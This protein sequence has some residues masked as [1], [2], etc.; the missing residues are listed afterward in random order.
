MD[1]KG[2]VYSCDKSLCGSLFIARGAVELTCAVKSAYFLEFK[3]VLQ[4]LRVAA[5]IFNGICVS[6]D[7]DVLQSLYG[8]EEFQLNVLGER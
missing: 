2:G 1:C 7:L 5:V 6:H 3:G 4:V 8:V